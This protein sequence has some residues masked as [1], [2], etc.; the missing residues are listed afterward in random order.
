MIEIRTPS[1]DDHPG[2]VRQVR[3]A[4][5]GNSYDD[6]AAEREAKVIDFD[7]FRIAYDT[8]L[9]RVVGTA[10]TWA[11][12]LTLPGLAQLPMAG[13]TW[14]AVSPTHRRQGVL[15]QM[16][17]AIH[18]DVVGRG[19]PI[20]GLLA[21]EATIYSRFGYAVAAWDRSVRIDR[22]LVQLD[23]R[24]VA[25]RGDVRLLPGNDESL[26][27]ELMPRWDRYRRTR[28]G[29][30]SRSEQW[31]RNLVDRRS[32]DATY[33]LHDDGY[34]AWKIK[35]DW[36][37]PFPNNQLTVVDFV[38]STD[39]ARDSLWSTILTM[40]LVGPVVVPALPLDDPLP[41]LLTN[42][43]AAATESVADMLWLNVF[44][45]ART[46]GARTYG[47]D[48]DI[49]VEVANLT[50][51]GARWK[52]GNAGC[53]RVRSRADVIVDQAAIGALVLGGTSLHTLAAARRLSARNDDVLRR[54]EHLFRSHPDP[55]CQTHF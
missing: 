8:V 52:I 7:R 19:E 51:R 54:A 23:G 9:K 36:D 6:A 28:V 20:A 5:G 40:D 16:I 2:M 49:V 34:A 15:R 25:P 26:L 18:D 13:L 44:D 43:R 50:E 10:G 12:D 35:Q 42:F 11:F 53:R 29:E 47:T 37:Q 4:F 22:R 45:M 14:V 48:D 33:A 46:F 24:Y 39:A 32:W 3:E 41:S 30:L 31:Q 21:S 1:G 38:A 55:W 17:E 27:G